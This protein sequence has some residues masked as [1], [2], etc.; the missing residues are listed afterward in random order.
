MPRRKGGPAELSKALCTGW[1]TQPE[2]LIL[3]GDHDHQS[4]I[5]RMVVSPKAEL[6][7]PHPDK[8]MGR[9]RQTSQEMGF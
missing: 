8:G 3:T 7:R 9:Q 4:S 1:S 2:E 5:N 6:R